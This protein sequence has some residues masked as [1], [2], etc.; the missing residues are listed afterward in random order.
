MQ[1]AALMRV[2]KIIMHKVGE[3]HNSVVVSIDSIRIQMNYQ[4]AL[5]WA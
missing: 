2:N 3:Y 4:W 5:P 1:M